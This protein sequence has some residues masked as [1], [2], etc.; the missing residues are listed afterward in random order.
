MSSIANQQSLINNDSPITNR[1]SINS[2]TQ[3]SPGAD[4]RAGQI[5]I[6]RRGRPG[7]HAERH[8]PVVPPLLLGK[9]GVFQLLRDPG[10]DDGLGGNLDGL[11][12]GRVAAHARLTLLDDEL[13][14]AGQ[15][16]FA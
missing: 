16:E 15:D 6:R 3:K 9:N 5:R 1:Q 7:G 11:T 13:H 8:R 12:R 10:F 14:H 2:S 4:G